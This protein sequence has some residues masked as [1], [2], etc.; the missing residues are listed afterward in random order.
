MTPPKLPSTL[1]EHRAHMLQDVLMGGR[2]Y[3]DALDEACREYDAAMEREKAKRK[4][5]RPKTLQ[6]MT[7]GNY[8]NQRRVA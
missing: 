8:P 2:Q 6:P 3:W 7:V 5:G 1:E 4:G